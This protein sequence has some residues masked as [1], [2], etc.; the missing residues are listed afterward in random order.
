[1]PSRN[2][3]KIYAEEQFY[4]I[5]NRGAHKQ[6]I[7]NDDQD[8]TVFLSLLKRILGKDQQ[9]DKFGRHYLHL[10][11]EVSIVTYC[12]MPN[13]FHLL[14]FNKSQMGIEK[15][16]RSIT[17]SYSMYYNRKY[18]H[19]GHVFEG[20]YKASL[21]E[22]DQYLQHITRY[23]HRN[24][25]H[26]AEYNYSSYQSLVKKLNVPWV[27]SETFWST[28]EGSAEEYIKFVEDYTDY[29]KSLEEITDQLANK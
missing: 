25:K 11:S 27:D 3:T 16:L 7:F 24:P 4:H 8:F 23:I 14:C 22:S 29:K 19:S 6:P 28:F 2:S 17:T 1:M 12:L 21:I 18:N 20:I 9:S 15:L 13:H 10:R 5:Y 26:Y